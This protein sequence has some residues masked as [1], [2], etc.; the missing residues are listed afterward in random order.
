MSQSSLI[1]LLLTNRV[2]LN[3]NGP[4]RLIYLNVCFPVGGIVWEGLGG[5]SL[6]VGSEVSEAHRK[7]GL[8]LLACPLGSDLCCSTAGQPRLPAVTPPTHYDNDITLNK[9]LLSQLPWPC[10]ITAL[11]TSYR[12]LTKTQTLASVPSFGYSYTNIFTL[13][14][15]KSNLIKT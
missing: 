3:E 12:R 5:M 14:C 8:C 2:G 6:W 4:Q 13:N 7:P 10:F 15:L 11:V 9:C 1:I